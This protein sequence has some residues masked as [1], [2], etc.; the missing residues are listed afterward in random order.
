MKTVLNTIDA[1][2][3]DATDKLKSSEAIQ[4]PESE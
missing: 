1:I 3:E 4:C 2:M